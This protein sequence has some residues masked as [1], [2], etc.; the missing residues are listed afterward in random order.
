REFFRRTT[1]RTLDLNPESKPDYVAD[2]CTRN[3]R[4]I[5]DGTFD[6][7]LITEVL[8]HTL[9]PFHVIAELYRILKPDGRLFLTVPFNFYIHS[10]LPDCWRFTAYGL[11][12][13]LKG[14]FVDVD[15][16]QMETP[17]RPFM[18]IHYTLTA[19]K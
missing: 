18:P 9:Q 15:I 3:D 4:L 11:R 14:L 13:L 17:D 10:P 16:W 2:I 1:V 12:A 19:R 7:V 6:Y 8:E 5:P